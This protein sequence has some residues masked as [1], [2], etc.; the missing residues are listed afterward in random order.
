MGTKHN[1]TLTKAE[2]GEQNKKTSWISRETLA[3][4]LKLTSLHN[5]HEDFRW[6]TPISNIF[7]RWICL[8]GGIPRE[9]GRCKSEDF[10][11]VAKKTRR[12]CILLTQLFV[13][14]KTK[15]PT[16]NKC[17]EQYILFRN[18]E[19]GQVYPQYPRCRINVRNFLTGCRLT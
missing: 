5:T 1:L 4:Q 19:C 7:R 13:N 2:L 17:C 11:G 12:N 14:D 10:F 8:K 15:K 16:I 6:N 3:A 9:T 18:D